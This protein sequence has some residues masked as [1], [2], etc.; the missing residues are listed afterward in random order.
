M[1]VV[2]C[3]II[4]LDIRVSKGCTVLIRL[5]LRIKWQFIEV[6]FENVYGTDLY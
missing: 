4:A 5:H 2:F 1:K 3:R 6:S